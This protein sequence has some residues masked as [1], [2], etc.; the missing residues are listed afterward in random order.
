MGLSPTLAFSTRLVTMTMAVLFCSHTIFQKSSTEFGRRPWVAMYSLSL[1]NPCIK[2]KQ[3]Q[4]LFM[5]KVKTDQMSSLQRSEVKHHLKVPAKFKV[6][7]KGTRKQVTYT[8]EAGIDVVRAIHGVQQEH[9]VLVIWKKNQF[10]KPQSCNVSNA[11][12]L[13]ALSEVFKRLKPMKISQSVWWQTITSPKSC[14]CIVTVSVLGLTHLWNHCYQV[15]QFVVDTLQSKHTRIVKLPAWNQITSYPKQT[16]IKSF[17]YHC[18]SWY[19]LLVLR[20]D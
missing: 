7:Q 12:L 19:L 6:W 2:G 20:H 17:L 15:T 10:N 16:A 14:Q 5:N 13:L 1:F 9:L 3:R 8:P 18:S 11:Y 4:I